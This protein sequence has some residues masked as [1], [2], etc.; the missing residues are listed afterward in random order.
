MVKLHTSLSIHLGAN[1]SLTAKA[2]KLQLIGVTQQAHCHH[3]GIRSGKQKASLHKSN[4]S[5]RNNSFQH[6]TNLYNVFQ[7][8]ELD[9]PLGRMKPPSRKTRR[10]QRAPPVQ[11]TTFVLQTLAMSL[12]SP[13]A[14]CWMRNITRNCLKNLKKEVEDCMLVEI[15]RPIKSLFEQKPSLTHCYISTTKIRVFSYS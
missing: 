9:K 4:I 15:S 7:T 8:D 12:K 3:M 2:L 1:I 14:I 10:T 11:A 5:S 13:A 6:A